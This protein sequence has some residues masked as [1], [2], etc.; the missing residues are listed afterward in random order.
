MLD[1]RRV[2]S[3]RQESVS[4]VDSDGA[5]WTN[6]AGRRKLAGDLT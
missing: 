3:L 1:L 6:C 2:L 4:V 5:P